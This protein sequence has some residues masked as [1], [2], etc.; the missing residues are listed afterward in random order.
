M[1]PPATSVRA[2][3]SAR[4][5]AVRARALA[6]L[7]EDPDAAGRCVRE[8]GERIRDDDVGLR[9]TAAVVLSK[10]G[11]D[12]VDGL[13]R[14]LSP[15]QPGSVR[16][17]AAAGLGSIGPEAEDAVDALGACLFAKEDDLRW[18][19][20][21]ALGRI[22][23]P[24]VEPVLRLLDVM[25]TPPPR[26]AAC[27]ALGEVGPPAKNAVKALK[28]L[29][30]ADEPSVRFAALSALALITEGKKKYIAPL[31]VQSKHE[32]PEV[33]RDA[34]VRIG[35]QRSHGHCAVKR[36]V[37]LLGDE[38]P[39]VRAEAAYTMG[40]IEA[41]PAKYTEALV[42]LLRDPVR[43][44]RLA[45]GAALSAFGPPAESALPEL[46]ARLSDPDEGVRSVA[47]AAVQSI[48]GE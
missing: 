35:R 1:A 18:H 40:R 44:V 28:R 11:R 38:E 47:R 20:S 21:R 31:I 17:Q 3:L 8:V 45:A 24:S 27:D 16:I 23:E 46:E 4:S 48:G 13:I 39:E 33:R 2:D 12:G 37:E 7:L 29:S 34:L 43:D 30:K 25:E 9:H 15:R 6:A 14:G 10:T 26:V 22:G 5:P 19:A 32:D 41:E 42:P 36:V